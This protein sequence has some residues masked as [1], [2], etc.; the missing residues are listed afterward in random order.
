[1]DTHPTLPQD[2]WEQT[3]PEVRAYIGTLEARV[4]ALE[5]MVQALQ[6]QNRALQEQLM[7]N[8]RNSSRPPSSDP[9]QAQRPKRPRSGRRRGGQPGHPGQT[10]TLIP[11]GE[12]HEVV[13]IKPKQCASCHAPLSGA[14]PRPF[15]H[16][17]IEIP[18]IEPIITEYQWHQLVCPECGETTRAPWP[19]GVPSGTYG[20][21]VHA[22][23]ALFS[24]SYR[25]SKRTT[26]QAMEELFGVPMSVGTISQSEKTTTEVLAEPV[27]D[28]R[29]YVQEQSVAHLDETSWRQAGKRTWLWVAVT[30]WVTVF[31][32]RL[33]RGGRVARELLGEKFNGILVTDRYSGYH[34]Y[35]VRWRQL[36]WSHLLRDFEAIRGRG[37]TSEAIG[38]ALLEQAHQM[39]TGWHRVREGTLARSTFRSYMTPLRREMERLLEVGS[40]CGVAKTEGTCRELLKRRQAL[41]TFVQVEGVE[42]TN[43]TAER[44]IRPGVQWRKGSF[45]TQSE[46]GSRFVESMLTV[47]ATLKQQNRPVLDYLTA[48]HE[49]ALRGEPAPSLLPQPDQQSQA[50]A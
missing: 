14:D 23:V 16:Q 43:N 13:P 1:M 49:A 29:G 8:S 2:L 41:W 37:G 9:P 47:V 33:S 42:P 17:V 46:A 48:A 6:E 5:A 28:A 45:G 7:Q 39:F 27:E 10:R 36:C 11:V 25:L 22:T 31:V 20:P 12:V 26:M 15:R 19:K 18:P 44:S 50:A 21:R 4:S 38:D 35:P 32:V 3:P 40:Q 24:G 30:S 34:W